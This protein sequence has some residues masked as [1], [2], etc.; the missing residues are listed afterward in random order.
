MHEWDDDENGMRR[1]K[2]VVRIANA[3]KR[4]YATAGYLTDMDSASIVVVEVVG[5][6][7]NP[8]T[9][10]GIDLRF[11]RVWVQGESVRGSNQYIKFDDVFPLYPTIQHTPDI[12]D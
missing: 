3:V 10:V 7:R 4:G 5:K 1:E 2:K 9:W 12:V 6:K 11:F 8:A